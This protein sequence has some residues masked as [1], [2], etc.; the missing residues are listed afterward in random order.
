MYSNRQVQT[1][2]YNKKHFNCNK[3]RHFL[4]D[5]QSPLTKETK[6]KCAEKAEKAKTANNKSLANSIQV[7]NSAESS[8]IKPSVFIENISNNI[9]MTNQSFEQFL[10][11][12]NMSHKNKE[13]KHCINILDLSTLIHMTSYLFCLQNI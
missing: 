13:T 9:L 1:R 8:S 10:N 7:L 12:Y 6:K 3:T 5:C 4:C 11:V 2:L